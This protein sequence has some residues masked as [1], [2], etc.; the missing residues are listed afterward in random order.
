MS[1]KRRNGHR[2]KP[3]VPLSK[4]INGRQGSED[5]NDSSMI[6]PTSSAYSNTEKGT[7]ERGPRRSERARGGDT[8]K[9]LTDPKKVGEDL[10]LIERAV[11]SRW[12]IRRKGMLQRRLIE[13]VEKR[14]VDA[15]FLTRDGIQR[16]PD[17]ALA[18][19]NAIAAAKVLVQMNG[20]DLEDDHF[21]EK[22]KKPSV[23]GTMVNVFNNTDP[24][25]SRILQLAQSLGATR[26]IIDGSEVRVAD[27][28]GESKEA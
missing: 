26:L 1:K 4:R 20:Q 27:S 16:E 8:G 28:P 9:L 5:Y 18:D 21:A 24:G 2:H 11:R 19:K 13:V 7:K 17:E 22:N 10:R 23:P 6:E 15:I 12:G 14:Q 3:K 25:Q